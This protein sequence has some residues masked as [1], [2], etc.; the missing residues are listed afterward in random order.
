V[1]HVTAYWWFREWNC[2]CW[3]AVGR[4]IFVDALLS[5]VLAASTLR[6]PLAG[7]AP[8]GWRW[9]MAEVGED[10]V[11]DV[12]EILTSLWGRLYGRSVGV[13]RVR[14]AVEVATGDNPA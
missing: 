6:L 14:R 11:R 3:L 9:N 8:G 10:L 2:R 7:R 4:L 1:Y 13:T 12:T 5:C